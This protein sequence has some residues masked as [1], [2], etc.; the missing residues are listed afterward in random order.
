MGKMTTRAVKS[1]TKQLRVAIGTLFLLSICT[2]VYICIIILYINP[3][4]KEK[5]KEKEEEFQHCG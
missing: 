5:E 1:S 4:K 3:T 2:S